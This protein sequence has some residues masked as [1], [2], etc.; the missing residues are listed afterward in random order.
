M[1]NAELS[2][3]ADG[4]ATRVIAWMKENPDDPLPVGSG[5]PRAEPFSIGFDEPSEPLPGT[6]AAWVARTEKHGEE[7]LA[8]MVALDPENRGIPAREFKR[9]RRSIGEND[10]QAEQM[11][12]SV[13]RAGLVTIRGSRTRAVYFRG[14]GDTTDAP[15]SPGLER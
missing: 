8:K 6:R 14:S 15:T 1:T 11:A 7:L 13:M 2:I 12:T 5:A 4:V 9:L 3:L 10:Y